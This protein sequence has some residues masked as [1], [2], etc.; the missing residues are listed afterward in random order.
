MLDCQPDISLD[1]IQ[2]ILVFV[3]AKIEFCID[4]KDVTHILNPNQLESNELKIHFNKKLIIYKSE[5]IALIKINELLGLKNFTMDDHTRIILLEI[6]EVK[7]AVIV[8]GVQSIISIDLS[9]RERLKF[10]PV[11]S[12]QYI[13]GKI[14]IDNADL[15]FLDIVQICRE[16]HKSKEQLSQI[17]GGSNE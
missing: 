6:N 13:K 1:K 16:L 8:E 4:F 14:K 10:L 15:L 2:G 3:L 5:S 9:T 12:N 7:F 11:Q 17:S